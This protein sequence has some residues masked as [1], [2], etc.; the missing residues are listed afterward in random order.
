MQNV[1]IK[2]QNEIPEPSDSDLGGVKILVVDDAEEVLVL[3]R[4][5]FRKE[6]ANVRIARSASTAMEAFERFRPHILISD[7]GMPE[8]D[9]LSLI[10]RL[11]ST[12]PTF[13]SSMRAIS[14]SAFVAEETKQAALLAGFDRH[15]RKP[16]PPSYLV[17][18]VANLARE[19]T[20]GGNGLGTRLI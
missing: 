14:F 10:R 11:R 15:V 18:L 20:P 12:F 3:L 19:V 4:A 2:A 6:G 9:G 5:V 16:A 7:L 13:V 17:S 8:E 1:N